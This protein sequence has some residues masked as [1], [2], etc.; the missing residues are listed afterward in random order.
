MT[1]ASAA[2]FVNEA[3]RMIL[4]LALLEELRREI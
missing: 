2:V 1:P 3:E 4:T